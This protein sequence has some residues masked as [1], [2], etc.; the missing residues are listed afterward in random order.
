MTML[1]TTL[2]SHNGKTNTT[3]NYFIAVYADATSSR[4]VSVPLPDKSDW[5]I[6]YVRQSLAG[7]LTISALTAAAA[8]YF[9]STLPVPPPCWRPQC[10]SEIHLQCLWLS[11][12]ALPNKFLLTVRLQ[13]QQQQQQLRRARENNRQP[14]N[15]RLRT[16][17]VARQNQTY[18][19]AD[20]PQWITCT[21]VQTTDVNWCTDEI[22][23]Y[24]TQPDT[25]MLQLYRGKLAN[26]TI[27]VLV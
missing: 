14:T 16:I 18:V 4:V 2:W 25:Q 7:E 9:A 8:A 26:H 11:T 24:N 21:G 13:Q 20:K 5:K 12:R 23:A 15:A 1:L 27:T 3:E 17:I 6:L 10:A 22:H 19:T